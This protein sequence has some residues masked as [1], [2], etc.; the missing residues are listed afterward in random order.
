VENPE[1]RADLFRRAGDRYLKDEND[2]RSAVRCYKHALDAGSDED[3]RITS[4]DNWLLVS[5]KNA[6]Q[7]ERHHGK[8]DG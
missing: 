3:L 5:L 1:R 8:N 4:Q 6:R 2:L 7:E